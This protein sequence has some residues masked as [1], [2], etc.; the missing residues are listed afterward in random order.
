[1][2]VKIVEKKKDKLKFEVYGSDHGLMNLL[3]EELAADKNVDFSTYS[4]PHPLLDGFV[5]TVIGKDP[6]AS[7]K[8]ALSAMES[9]SKDV[10]AAFAKAK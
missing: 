1:M 2:E 3:R 8:K 9:Y 4:T 7:V 5:V 10:K 6:E